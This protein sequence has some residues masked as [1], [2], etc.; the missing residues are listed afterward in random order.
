M[1]GEC[2]YTCINCFVCIL[3][4]I[5]NLAVRRSVNRLTV[6]CAN[7][8]MTTA[9]GPSLGTTVLG[10]TASPALNDVEYRG[11]PGGRWSD[12]GFLISLNKR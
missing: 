11:H 8:P 5:L 6:P 12:T 1:H 2:M 10:Q 3:A 9:A 7:A 4:C